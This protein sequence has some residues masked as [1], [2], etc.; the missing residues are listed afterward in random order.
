MRNLVYRVGPKTSDL[1][2]PE[3]DAKFWGSNCHA[4]KH[5]Y[6]LGFCYIGTPEALQEVNI[7]HLWFH[8]VSYTSMWSQNWT[9]LAPSKQYLKPDDARKGY[10]E[11]TMPTRHSSKSQGP[12]NHEG[13]DQENS[14]LVSLI[15]MEVKGLAAPGEALK[16]IKRDISFL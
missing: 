2:P 14:M 9:N 10:N 1:P 5:C 12:R 3:R 11:P 15:T 8:H 13:Q 16:N 7:G 4:S 6:L